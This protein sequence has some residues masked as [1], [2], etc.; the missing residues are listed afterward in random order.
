MYEGEA[1]ADLDVAN[2]VSDEVSASSCSLAMFFDNHYDPANEIIIFE[3]MARL[4]SH[5]YKTFCIE[6]YNDMDLKGLVKFY[7]FNLEKER[8]HIGDNRRHPYLKLVL[9]LLK[10]AEGVKEHELNFVAI[11]MTENEVMLYNYIKSKNPQ[12]D[13]DEAA[14]NHA[15]ATHIDSACQKYG[16]KIIVLVGLAHGELQTLLAQKGYS[17]IKSFWI[18]K[19]EINDSFGSF[20]LNG[21]YLRTSG[22][23]SFP[24]GLSIIDLRYNYSALQTLETQLGLEPGKFTQFEYEAIYNRLFA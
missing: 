14:R 11:D 9:P 24:L 1:F 19:D 23:Y 20:M 8:P 2:T 16:G 4:K 3:L 12:L 5:G 18:L 15:M 7:Q 21:G 22:K 13:I 6:A 17:D 10:I